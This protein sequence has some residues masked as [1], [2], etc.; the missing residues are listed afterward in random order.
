MRQEMKN[1]ATRATGRAPEL[2]SLAAIDPEDNR[3]HLEIQRLRAIARRASLP[4]TVAAVVASLA[5]GEAR[6]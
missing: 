6:S 1:P 4:L 3:A 2:I 5:F